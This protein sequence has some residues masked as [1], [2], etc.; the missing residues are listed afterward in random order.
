MP[1]EVV[2]NLNGEPIN[3]TTI[4]LDGTDKTTTSD[5]LGIYRLDRIT[6]DDY[7]INVSA[8]GYTSQSVIH[9]ISRGKIDEV[10][11]KLGNL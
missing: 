7:K 4:K 10:N 3:K 8:A 1:G 6:P 9:H 2:T 11:F 5:L